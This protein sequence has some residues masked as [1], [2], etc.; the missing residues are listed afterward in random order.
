MDPTVEDTM[1]LA[2][3][4]WWLAQRDLE[5]REGRGIMLLLHRPQ[6]EST[7]SII[8]NADDALGYFVGLN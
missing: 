2:S 4:Q 3:F 6:G 7:A 8:A 1:V 5:V